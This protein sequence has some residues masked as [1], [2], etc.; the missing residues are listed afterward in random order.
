MEDI[1]PPI[2]RLSPLGHCRVDRLPSRGSDEVVDGV[3]QEPLLQE[4]HDRTGQRPPGIRTG[5]EV[6]RGP[7]PLQRRQRPD[8]AMYDC[9]DRGAADGPRRV[10]RRMICVGKRV[11]SGESGSGKDLGHLARL[12]EP[13]KGMNIQSMTS[14]REHS[15]SFS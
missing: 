7:G 8:R 9:P 4:R 1:S 3:L 13:T 11:P 5:L 6:D 12:F 15:S 10:F 2:Q 14:L